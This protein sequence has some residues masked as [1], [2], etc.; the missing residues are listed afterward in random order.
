MDGTDGLIFDT[1]S[2]WKNE[3]YV[4]M[5]MDMGGSQS[6]LVS[7]NASRDCMALAWR[8]IAMILLV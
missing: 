6:F 8:C 7:K 2:L 4:E 1:Y 5:G 3:T